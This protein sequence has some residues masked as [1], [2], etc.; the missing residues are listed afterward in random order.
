MVL[1]DTKDKDTIRAREDTRDETEEYQQLAG[2]PHC[3]FGTLSPAKKIRF[4]TGK[5]DGKEI[6]AL[7]TCKSWA[8]LRGDKT[9]VKD[10]VLIGREYRC[11]LLV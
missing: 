5:P 10:I 6:K 3:S 2:I 11:V 1:K 7:E 9:W 4:K 8:A